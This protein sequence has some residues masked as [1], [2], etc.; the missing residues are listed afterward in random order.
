MRIKWFAIIRLIGLMLVLAYHFFQPKFPGGFIGV[1]LFFTFSGYLVTAM[2][3]DEYSRTQMIDV[4]GFVK[5]RIYRIIP[6][7][8]LMIL[9]VMPLTLLVKKDFVADI[10]HQLAAALG[11]TT[12]IYEL[13]TGGNY[14]SQFIPHLFLHTWSLAIEVQFYLFWVILVAIIARQR[15]KTNRFRGSLFLLSTALFGI[16]FV[17]LFV[18]AFLTENFSSLY[19]STTGRLFAFFL[20]SI[21]ATQTG[22][23]YTTP[24]FQRNV[25]LWK[26]PQTLFFMLGSTG[27]L[28]LLAF[29]LE[30]NHIVTYAFGL[31]LASFFTGL[32]IYSTRVLHEQTPGIAEPSWL[33]F[34][35]DISYGIY[36]FHWPLYIIFSQLLSQTVAVSLTLGLSVFFA[37]L[38]F[39][40]IEPLLA[41]KTPVFAGQTWQPPRH[42]SLVY[43]SL[44]VLVAILLGITS[45]APRVGAFETNLLVSS[46]TQAQSNLNRTH[47]L[48]AGDATAISDVV[49]IG[50][51]VTLRAS[52]SISTSLPEA[53]LDAAVSRSFIDAYDIFQ[54]Q[55]EQQTLPKTVVI[56]VGVNSVYNYQ[57][58]IDRFVEGLP[59][60]HR[61]ILVTPYNIKDGRVPAVRDYELALAKK[62]DYITIAD[63]YQAANDTPSIW[64]G[65]DGVHFSDATSE[66]ADLYAK[67]IK[68]AIAKA[69]KRSAKS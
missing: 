27:L 58:D 46:L 19:F 32:L 34:L 13:V 47:T 42:K 3:L 44:S 50:D 25:R 29:L 51:S 41:G 28:V 31:I 52:P 18:R 2:F 6:P 9:L 62:H 56:A 16:S 64:Q 60:G 20:G 12:N 22:I 63:W 17:S 33:G 11:F 53:E 15:V 69:A 7:L 38:S 23:A 45:T 48:A 55:I 39:K 10:G 21:F 5:R 36:L 57:A 26:R 68:K 61:L 1:D 54:N 4:I 67:T 37:T 43:A 14:E 66:G 35:S 59:K 24:R 65:T 40:I 8:V 49:I 30:F